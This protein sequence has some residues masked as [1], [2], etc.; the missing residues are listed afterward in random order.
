MTAAL[1]Q[2]WNVSDDTLVVAL[3]ADTPRRADAMDGLTAIGLAAET[4]RAIRLLVHPQAHHLARAQRVA[5]AM[6]RPDRLILDPRMTEPFEAL[7][8][9]DAALA[10]GDCGEQAVAWAMAHALPIVAGRPHDL[11]THDVNAW[12]TSDA[13]DRALAAAVRQL[14]DQPDL[15]RRLGQAARTTLADHPRYGKLSCQAGSD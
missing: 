1:R 7:A 13:G 14:Y 9:A 12:V 11:L 6:D 10:L 15:R 2:A 8:D 5:D 4:G 3:I